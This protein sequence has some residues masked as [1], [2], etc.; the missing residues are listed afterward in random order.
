MKQCK[1]CVGRFGDHCNKTCPEGHYGIGCNNKCA[2]DNNLCDK[3]LGCPIIATEN[4]NLFP[5]ID[6]K[7]RYLRIIL[8]LA[9][10]LSAFI[11]VVLVGVLLRIAYRLKRGEGT[12]NDRSNGTNVGNMMMADSSAVYAAVV[13]TN[14][15][16]IQGVQQNDEIIIPEC[17]T[18][19]VYNN[20][21]KQCIAYVGSFGTNCSQSCPHGYYGRRCRKTCSCN[22]ILCDNVL[23][24]PEAASDEGIM[25]SSLVRYSDV[26]HPMTPPELVVEQKDVIYVNMTMLQKL[27]KERF[28]TTCCG[29]DEYI[30]IHNNDDTIRKICE[31]CHGL[32]CR[33]FPHG[34]YGEQCIETCSCGTELCDDV[35]GCVTTEDV[36]SVL[37]CVGRFGVHCNNICPEG[38]Y[39]IGCNNRC[40]CENN[41][42]DK[43][44]GC[45]INATAFITIVL[46]GVLLRIAY[47]LKRGEGTRN[48]RSNETNV[49]NMMMADSSAVYAAVVCTNRT[50]IQGV[51]QNDEISAEDLENGI[52]DRIIPQCCT[53][54]V[55]NDTLMQ[56]IACVGRFGTNCSQSC[57]QVYYGRRCSQTCSC[58]ITLCDNVLG[59]S[60]AA[61]DEGMMASSLVG[62]SDVGHPMNPPELVVEENDVIYVNTMMLQK[63]NNKRGRD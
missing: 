8:H 16:P 41:L 40:V 37:A 15:T 30:N 10:S 59:C 13:C 24:C 25:A 42:C 46:V 44:L 53:G 33:K 34:Y 6:K 45:L 61:S 48:D 58:N 36:F 51:Q 12:R 43:V 7:R 32:P 4:G 11:T 27:D 2:C 23:G 29:N 55:Y 9:L 28:L 63:L 38:H 5:V 49:G 62:Y 21:L 35:L 18:D 31:A 50:P 3:V 47:R 57:P 20:T 56:C 52:C 60:E 54:F 14:R 17:C 19:F 22:I 39:G 26:G 1:A